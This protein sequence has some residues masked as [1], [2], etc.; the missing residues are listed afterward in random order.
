V[1][2]CR[3]SRTGS[4]EPAEDR[5]Q[6]AVITR[7]IPH[8]V[9]PRTRRTCGYILVMGAAPSTSSLT[10]GPAQDFAIGGIRQARDR[11]LGAP[12]GSPVR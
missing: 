6:Q 7:Q 12:E 2:F 4:R 11:A 8:Q 9:G 1:A 3:Q 10:A 5:C